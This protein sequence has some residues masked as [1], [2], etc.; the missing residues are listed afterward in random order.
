V[1]SR[2]MAM[3]NSNELKEVVKVIFDQMAHLKINADHAGIVVDYEPKKDFHFWVADHQDIP[4]RITVPYLDLVWDRQF[5]E[6]KKKG[7]GFLFQ[8]SGIGS[9][10]GYTKGYRPLY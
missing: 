9:I 4:A 10:N 7:T 1:R 6:A 5:T 2:S 8:L 3:H